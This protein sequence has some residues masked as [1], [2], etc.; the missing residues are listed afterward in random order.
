MNSNTSSG[1]IP[2]AKFSSSTPN[3]LK[4]SSLLIVDNSSAVMVACSGR[5]TTLSCEDFERVHRLCCERAGIVAEGVNAA[6]P[7]DVVEHADRR[8]VAR[9]ALGMAVVVDFMIRCPGVEVSCP[10]AHA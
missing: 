4:C 3:N 8:D 7:I 6:T 5:P 2:N 1:S 10:A 9:I